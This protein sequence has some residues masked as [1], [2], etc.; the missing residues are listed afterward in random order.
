MKNKN[1]IFGMLLVG[2]LMISLV[3]AGITSYAIT[4][5]KTGRTAVAGDV[6]V[7]ILDVSRSG[8]ASVQVTNTQT[9]ATERVAVTEGGTAL[10]KFGEVSV[11][12]VT[13]SSLFRKANVE[14]ITV[15][16]TTTQ[17]VT[18]QDAEECS[19]NCQAFTER[20]RLDEGETINIQGNIIGIDFIDADSVKLNVNGQPTELFSE[21]Q[22]FE[23]S[24]S[25]IVEVEDIHRLEVAGEIGW[26]I[27]G[28]KGYKLDEG[29][30]INLQGNL[31]NIDF[32]DA[33]EVRLNVNNQLTNLLIKDNTFELNNN[34]IAVVGKIAKLEVGGTTGYVRIDLASCYFPYF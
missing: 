28:L 9:G 31:I 32:I 19:N 33:D 12:A 5:L 2:V 3:S 14:S 21:N 22:W 17:I 15:T 34:Q 18:S 26:V 29:E 13:P 1:L 27:L 8:V 7:K 25:Q 23:L 24:N 30:T 11:G 4:D 20:Y 16:P 6:N 10:T